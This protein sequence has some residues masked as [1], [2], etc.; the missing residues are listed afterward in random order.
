MAFV[1]V[2]ST[3]CVHAF[4]SCLSNDKQTRSKASLSS[5]D[6]VFLPS[7]SYQIKEEQLNWWFVWCPKINRR[8]NT[9]VHSKHPVISDFQSWGTYLGVKV[10][11]KSGAWTTK[12]EGQGQSKPGEPTMGQIVEGS[13]H[14][15]W[16]FALLVKKSCFSIQQD[17]IGLERSTRWSGHWTVWYA[18]NQDQG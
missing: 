17:Q 14:N 7:S 5:A 8:Q 11:E 4:N 10:P 18:L 16:S 3:N 6:F 15:S 2:C 9:D 1:R 12:P 13:L